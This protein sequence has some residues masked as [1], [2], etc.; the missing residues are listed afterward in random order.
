[1]NKKIHFLVTLG[2]TFLLLTSC[3]NEPISENTSF[4]TSEDTGVTSEI[5]VETTTETPVE[6]YYSVSYFESELYKLNGPSQAKEGEE[7]NFTISDIAEGYCLDY[8]LVNNNKTITNSFTMPAYNSLVEAV[9]VSTVQED[10]Y[11]IRFVDS[12]YGDIASNI[13]KAKPGQEVPIY[14]R[15]KE[16]YRL[17]KIKANDV[18]LTIHNNADHTYYTHTI[19]QNKPLVVEA[20]FTPIEQKFSQYAFSLRGGDFTNSAES[21]WNFSYL[22]DG[23]FIEVCVTDPTLIYNASLAVWARD[24]V[25]L[26]MCIETNSNRPQD[27]KALRLMLCSDGRYN[28]QRLRSDSA[29]YPLGKYVGYEYGR[30][31]YNDAV[32]C[33]KEVNGFD[34]Y[35]VKAF[36]GY[37]IFETDYE[38]ALGKITFAPAMRDIMS[39]NHAT[40]ATDTSWKSTSI[41]MAVSQ[42]SLYYNSSYHCQWWNPRTYI[43]VN[44]D[45]TVSDRYLSLDTDLL[46]MGDSYTIVTRYG[47]MYDDFS[48]LKV[49]T[50]GFGA[51]KTSDWTTGS[52]YHLN[53]LS[54]IQPKNIALHIGGNDL[55]GGVSLDTAITNLK[56]MIAGIFNRLPNVNVYLMS[57]VHR[58]Y[59]VTTEQMNTNNSFNSTISSYYEN[60]ERVHFCN[61]TDGFLKDDG[62]PNAGLFTDKTHANSF[63]YAII[64]GVLRDTMGLSKLSDS[65][66]FGSFGKNYATNGFNYEKVGEIEYLRQRNSMSKFGD[67]YVYFK[68]DVNTDFTASASFNI[69]E[70]YNGDDNP[71]F[72]FILNDGES[73]LF[74]Y[75]DTNEYFERKRVGVASRINGTYDWNYIEPKTYNVYFLDD[76]YTELSITRNGSILSFFVNGYKIVDMYSSDLKDNY[77]VGFFSFNL[78]LNVKNPSLEMGGNN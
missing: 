73:Q 47:S 18:Y 14:V 25:E 23:L 7:V 63:G 31:F 34:G 3:G 30:N 4:N 26:Q 33:T 42:M 2:F 21:F 36:V 19:M 40:G 11:P 17:N 35:V 60:E 62:S 66:K 61:I 28:F 68:Q 49:S 77:Q 1:M 71:K 58:A 53:I 20:E 41:T 46:F 72:G 69:S 74:Y 55:Y 54:T 6:K 45:G 70:S 16:G 51:S 48:D 50:I 10:D 39:Y 29:Y 52:C 43:R 57:I 8:F 38:H 9:L 65:E 37:D 64:S 75:V 78:A 12:L 27:V 44:A 67:R 15:A 59:N 56:T 13:E 22:E 32:I 76:D 5:S 24:N